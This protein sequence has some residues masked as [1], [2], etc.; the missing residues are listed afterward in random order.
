MNFIDILILAFIGLF[1]IYGFRKGF[2]ISLASIVSLVLGIYAAIHFSNYLDAVIMERL[3]PSK[4]W[5]PLLSFTIIFF[6]VVIV[7]FIVARLL[8]K[9][10]DVVGM[11]FLNR[12][13]GALLGLIKGILLASIILFIVA[14]ADPGQEWITKKDKQDSWLIKN[15]SAVFPEV[16]KRLGDEIRF[17]E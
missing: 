5:L 2:I 11:G 3:E 15:V 6:A 10:I 7:V 12:L 17:P 9:V 1:V 4:E 8:E 14:K 16:M 13:G